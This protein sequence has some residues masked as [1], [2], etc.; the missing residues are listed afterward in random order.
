MHKLRT[1]ILY[2]C[3]GIVFMI[4][5]LWV[6]GIDFKFERGMATTALLVIYACGG[7]L[8]YSFARLKKIHED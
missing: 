3:S 8:G 4:G 5:F 2:T 6:S 7:S 1:R